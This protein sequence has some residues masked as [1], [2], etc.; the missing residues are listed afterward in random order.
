MTK[1]ILPVKIAIVILAP[2]LAT[3]LTCLLLGIAF[4][5]LF[6]MPEP[7][8]NNLFIILEIFIYLLYTFGFSVWLYK[9]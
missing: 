8:N 5:I 9:K 3:V 7:F 6:C 1:L 2:A 4:K